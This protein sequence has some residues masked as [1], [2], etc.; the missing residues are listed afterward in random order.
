MTGKSG[1]DA[2]IHFHLGLRYP[3]QFTQGVVGGYSP[4]M[5][6]IENDYRFLQIKE[7][8]AHQ[9]LAATG[10]VQGKLID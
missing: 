2:A 7:A 3:V 8:A 10:I 9:K 5:A 6:M 4:G 1:L